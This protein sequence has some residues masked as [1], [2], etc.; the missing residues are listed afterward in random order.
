MITGR[1]LVVE[2]PVFKRNINY[3]HGNYF[4]YD[5]DTGFWNSPDFRYSSIPSIGER[6]LSINKINK[7]LKKEGWVPGVSVS[8]T[9]NA[10][11]KGVIKYLSYDPFDCWSETW[12]RYETIHVEFSYQDGHNYMAK[13]NKDELTKEEENDQNTTSDK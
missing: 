1:I 11:V 7:E 5:D 12:K 10:L 6:M 4:D 3:N 2:E 8:R 13:Y 9:N